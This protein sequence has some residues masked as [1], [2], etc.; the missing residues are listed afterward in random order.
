MTCQVYLDDEHIYIVVHFIAKTILCL[1][2]LA[3]QL[4]ILKQKKEKKIKWENTACVN[5]NNDNGG[6]VVEKNMIESNKSQ[7]MKLE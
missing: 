1:S 4:R 3:I 7:I 5:R 2:D 6:I